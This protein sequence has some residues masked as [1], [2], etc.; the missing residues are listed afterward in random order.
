MPTCPACTDRMSRNYT[1]TRRNTPQKCT[2]LY[3]ILKF[4]RVHYQEKGHIGL[5][6]LEIQNKNQNRQRERCKNVIKQNSNKN[7]VINIELR[8]KLDKVGYIY[9]ESHFIEKIV[10]NF[11]C[12]C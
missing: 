1:L 6:C 3:I 5:R 11:V 7:V 9:A 12:K 8:K 4:N 10:F 2:M